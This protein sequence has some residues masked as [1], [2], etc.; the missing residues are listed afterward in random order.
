MAGRNT[1]RSYMAWHVLADN[2]IRADSNVISDMDRPEYFSSSSYE[3]VIPKGR[4]LI[5][6]ST[7]SN[8]MF[9]V[10]VRA[11]FNLAVDHGSQTV[12]QDKPWAKIGIT[13]YDAAATP[14]KQFVRHHSKGS[15]FRSLC[16]LHKPVQDHSCSAIGAE[17]LASCVP[18]VLAIEQLGFSADIRTHQRYTLHS[19]MIRLLLHL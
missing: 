3:N 19:G 16:S 8:L 17:C 4:R 11:A 14:Q 10:D 1:N 13:T 12:N 5:F 2:G 7:D 18:R 6:V 15:E 9:D